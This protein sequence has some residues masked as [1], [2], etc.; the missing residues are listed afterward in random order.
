MD[1]RGA[2]ILLEEALLC[3]LERA[4][5]ELVSSRIF[6]RSSAAAPAPL[7]L[8]CRTAVVRH[9]GVTEMGQ[10]S[11]MKPANYSTP[12]TKSRK[13][14]IHKNK[15]EKKKSFLLSLLV[16]EPAC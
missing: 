14:R 6:S 8:H 7:R 15:E 9:L 13:M 12:I 3:A 5:D 16:N 10:D 2:V 4:G 11:R 1:E